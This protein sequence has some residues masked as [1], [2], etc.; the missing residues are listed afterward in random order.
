QR[1]AS[2]HK[3]AEAILIKV[4]ILWQIQDDYLDAFA[5]PKH[6]GKIGTDIQDGKC[7][8]PLVMSLKLAGREQRQT[9]KQNFGRPEPEC[10][11]RVKQV[12]QQLEI[13]RLYHQH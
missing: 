7:C 1:D 8:W 9:L 2:L 13:E 10:V 3:D 4:G 6:T 12:Y 11:E 5:D